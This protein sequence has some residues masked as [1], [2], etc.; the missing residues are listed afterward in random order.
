MLTSATR[1]D[2]LT[3]LGRAMADPSR[4]RI[5]AALTAG[6]VY[7]AE[8]ADRLRMTRSNVSNHLACLRGC[9]LVVAGAE[10]RRTRYAIADPH[11]AHA[12]TSLVDVVLAVDEGEPCTNDTCDVPGCCA[13][14][15]SELDAR[16]SDGEQVEVLA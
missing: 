7:P 16:V 14:C 10:G 2:A 1:I 13:D 3:R 9:G 12:L 8:L 4:A 15:D 11:L 6:P 5:L